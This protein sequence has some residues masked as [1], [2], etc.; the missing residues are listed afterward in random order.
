LLDGVRKDW[1]RKVS[2][3]SGFPA[4]SRHDLTEIQ[5]TVGRGNESKGSVYEQIGRA[6]ATCRPDAGCSQERQDNLFTGA[7][8]VGGMDMDNK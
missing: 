8:A 2:P 4:H 7:I 5:V 6:S 1:G 3:F